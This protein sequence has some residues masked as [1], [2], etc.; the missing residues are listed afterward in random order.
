MKERG[1][2][3]LGPAFLILNQTI[4]IDLVMDR[5]HWMLLIVALACIAALGAWIVELDWGLSESMDPAPA[6]SQPR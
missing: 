3:F 1:Q 4:L 2:G 6:T 5:R